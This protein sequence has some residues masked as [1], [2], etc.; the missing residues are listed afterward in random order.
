VPEE[1][2][3]GLR[4][5]ELVRRLDDL[6]GGKGGASSTDKELAEAEVRLSA[7]VTKLHDTVKDLESRVDKLEHALSALHSATGAFR[8]G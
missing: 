5:E 8:S 4:L 2:D 1:Q 6:E 3:A 7:E